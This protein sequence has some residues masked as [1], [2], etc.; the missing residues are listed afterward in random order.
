MPSFADL[1]ALVPSGAEPLDALS[2][3]APPEPRSFLRAMV[4]RNRVREHAA[5]AVPRE[6]VHAAWPKYKRRFGSAVALR[7]TERGRRDARAEE[8]AGG[9]AVWAAWQLGS[10]MSGPRGK[11]QGGV[12]A[13]LFLRAAEQLVSLAGGGEGARLLEMEIDY[14][15]SGALPLLATCLCRLKEVR[16]VQGTDGRPARLYEAE[17]VMVDFP[18][19]DLCSYGLATLV[20]AEDAANLPAGCVPFNDPA[21]AALPPH[22]ASPARGTG[23]YASSPVPQSVP[24]FLS[25]LWNARTTVRLTNLIPEVVPNPMMSER[26]GFRGGFIWGTQFGAEPPTH[27]APEDEPANVDPDTGGLARRA[28]TR[29]WQMLDLSRYRARPEGGRRLEDAEGITIVRLGTGSASDSRGG[30]VH[31]GFLFSL[32]DHI[33]GD[34]N[35]RLTGGGFTATIYFAFPAVPVLRVPEAGEDSYMVVRSRVISNQGR[36][37]SVLGTAEAMHAEGPGRRG[38]E[39]ARCVGLFVG[40]KGGG[41]GALGWRRV[42]L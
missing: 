19:N 15:K 18:A 10:I 26:D 32:V 16:T 12:S 6:R 39:A 24:P 5:F 4:Q 35:A 17:C 9:R 14:I 11:A 8:R 34:T 40:P 1:L 42:K 25:A 21:L 28:F 36:K 37:S 7:A 23:F 41:E 31:R 20:A 27:P 38:P 30:E 29:A 33:C 13:V 22:P 2:A 3:S